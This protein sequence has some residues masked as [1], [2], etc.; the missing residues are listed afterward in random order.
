MKKISPNLLH[1]ATSVKNTPFK[2]S[3]A[4]MFTWRNLIIISEN[5]EYVSAHGLLTFGVVIADIFFELLKSYL[6]IKIEIIRSVIKYAPLAVA[7]DPMLSKQ[8]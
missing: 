7:I 2:T 1:D 5:T 3:M 6:T 8:K 4:T